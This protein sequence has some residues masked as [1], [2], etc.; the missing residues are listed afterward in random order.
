MSQMSQC[1]NVS[2]AE[3]NTIP[4]RARARKWCITLN[5]YTDAEY[6]HMVKELSSYKYV[7]GKEVGAEG[8]PH[9]QAYFEWTNQIDFSK[10]K[11]LFPRAHIE[12]AKG[13]TEQNLD[14]CS[15]EGDYVTNI[16]RKP[17]KVKLDRR[18]MMLATYERVVWKDWQQ[19][20][21]DIVGTLPDSRTIHWFYEGEGNVGKSYLAKYLVLKYNAIICSGKATDVF[22]QV[23]VWMNN[24]EDKLGPELV[25]LD[26]PRCMADY[27]S[28]QAIECL[29]NGMLYSGKYEGGVC[30]FPP[31][32]VICFSNHMPDMGELSRDRWHIVHIK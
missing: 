26:C 2:N 19:E 25:V 15:K 1:L 32:H 28:Y 10:V 4:P 14:Y 3:G 11:K 18:G 30:I 23:N 29:K 24:N 13:S 17:V 16:E 9:L 12:K 31:P 22:N 20:V 27:V 5:N 7:I 21:I 8:T 6:E